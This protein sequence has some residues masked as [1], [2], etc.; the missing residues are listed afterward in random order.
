MIIVTGLNYVGKTTVK[1]RLMGLMGLTEA[2]K[3]T[4]KP[5]NYTEAYN[6]KCKC[7]TQEEF[8]KMVADGTFGWVSKDDEGNLW[9]ITRIE[10]AD[11]TKIMELDFPTYKMMETAIPSSAKILYVDSDIK[12]RYH[13]AM[14]KGIS[15]VAVFHAIHADNFRDT[16][17]RGVRVNNSR[18]D[19]GEFA[20][21]NAAYSLENEYKEF[22]VVYACRI[23][24]RTQYE[25]SRF[26][27]PKICRFLDFELETIDRAISEHDINTL[28][29][30]EAAKAQ[31]IQDMDVY[32]CVKKTPAYYKNPGDVNAPLHIVI[33]LG[34]GEYTVVDKD[35][36]SIEPFVKTLSKK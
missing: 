17:T 8:D 4:T 16:T 6:A 19:H 32:A 9:G 24:P 36:L 12:S 18:P 20:A 22:G 15:E 28:E 3:I 2:H 33:E 11:E 5:M 14:D 29:G 26:T 23:P 13:R 35:K 27:E 1:N 10:F 7:I 25:E 34:G 30:L 21:A 31:Y